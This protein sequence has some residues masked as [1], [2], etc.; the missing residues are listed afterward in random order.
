VLHQAAAMLRALFDLATS[1]DSAIGA[2]DRIGVLHGRLVIDDKTVG[3]VISYDD[4]SLT[5][6]KGHA[7]MK[8]TLAATDRERRWSAVA[9]ATGEPGA[10]RVFDARLR[11][12]SIDEIALVGGFRHLKFDT[13]SRISLDAHFALGQDDRVLEANG[14]IRVGPG[15]FRLEDPDHE[16]VMIEAVSGAMHWDRELRQFVIAP[17]DFKAGGFDMAL[18]G[19]AVAPRADGEAGALPGA[20]GAWS[21]SIRLAKPT[22]VAPE[23]AREKGVAIE[24]GVLDASY[25][26]NEKKLVFDKFAF[27]GPDVNLSLTGEVGWSQGAHV[28]YSLTAADTQIRALTRLWPT[29]VATT[30][31]SWFIDHVPAGVLRRGAYSADFDEAAL[32]AMRYGQSPPDKSVGA[33]FELVG[34]T[35]TEAM[36]GLPPI[37]GISGRARV[38]GRT[39]S[40]TASSGTM[41]TGPG[42]RLNVAEGRFAVADNMIVPTPATL[43]LRLLGSLEA[44]ADMLALPSISPYASLPVDAAALRGQVDGRMRVEFEMGAGARG[45]RTQ[46]SVD[47]LASNVAIEHFVGKER[48]ENATLNVVS[49]RAGLRVTGA[50]R[51]YGAP[52]TLELRRP[53]GD[54]GPAQAQLGLSFDEAARTKAGFGL[55]GVGGPIAAAIKTQL[56]IEEVDAQIEL[57]LTRASLE[58]PLPGLTKPAGKPAKAAFVLAK[59]PE[60]MTLDRFF[61]EAGA[62]QAQGVIELS[63]EG[64]FRAAK[65]SQARLSPGDDMRVEAQRAGD[66]L[67][68]TVRG[69][70]ID[71]RPVLRSLMTGGPERGGSSG[72]GGKAPGGF[73]DIDLDVKSPIVTGH[74]KQILSNVDLKMER[75]NGRAR[76]FSLSGNFGRERLAVAM[77]QGQNGAPQLEIS[78]PD[79]GSFLAFLDFYQKMDGGA[80]TASVQIGQNRADGALRISDFRLKHEPTLRQLMAQG[81]ADRPER[82]GVRSDPDS[83]RIGQLQSG[84]TWSSG[85]LSVRE[86][87]M[88]GPEIGLTFDGYIDFTRETVDLGGSYVPAYALNS[89]LSNIP[90]LNVFITGGQNEGIFALNY[91]LSGSLNSPVVTVNPLSVIAP[92]LMRK[93]MGIMDGSVRPVDRGR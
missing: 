74:G 1:P 80:L 22:V 69:A 12:I 55:S 72:G 26:Q 54:R 37:T 75:R 63:R 62:A 32:T 90:V 66:A 83:V 64:G 82:G 41:E 23:R 76:A 31:R 35:L 58:N 77:A 87:V 19:S 51:L 91:R 86:G 56:P 21:F 60:G 48:L 33:D 38:T 5:L 34:A 61:F 39:G 93:I 36:A 24:R 11:D 67:K 8:F 9:T 18:E 7:G 28:A 89:L 42:R 29:H 84:F 52:A 25:R 17:I 78:T 14:R 16:P 10:R 46:L 50:G 27:S 85:R 6:D 40:F 73:E 79:G 71:A 20:G 44:V 49:D 13:D 68:I 47:A 92:G 45:D 15:F 43:H 81:G 3:R 88:S 57:D 53:H 65:L 2:I 4:L 30:V 70:N 59:R